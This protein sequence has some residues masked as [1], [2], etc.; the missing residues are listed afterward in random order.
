MKKIKNA[1]KNAAEL[2]L[3][4]EISDTS[5]WGDEVTPKQMADDLAALGD[6]SEIQVRINSPGGDVFAGVAIHSMLKRHNA[7]ITVYVDGLAASI[8]SIIA[9]AGD[10]IIMPKG[11]MLMIHNPWSM[12]FG[13]ANDFRQM[14][15][16]LDTIRGSMIPIYAEKTG[17]SEDDII[18]LLDAETWLTAEDAIAQGFATEIEESTKVAASIRGKKAVVNGLEMDLSKFLNKPVP[19]DPEIDDDEDGGPMFD[20]GDDVQITIPPRVPGQSSG[21]VREAVLCYVYGVLFDGDEDIYHWYT[22]SEL[23]EL[24][25]SV[26]P[27][28]PV[29]NKTKTAKSSGRNLDMELRNLSLIELTT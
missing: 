25:E 13:D 20:V 27:P 22:E 4:G 10:K 26:E 5:W 23:K 8:A 12:A 11:S 29:Q 17:L 6:V 14:A 24:Q 1:A 7:S 28:E 21:T 9:M 16:T 3:Y 18:A 2:I 19:E 15:D